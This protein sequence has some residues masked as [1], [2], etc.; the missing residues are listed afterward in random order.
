MKIWA[1]AAMLAFALPAGGAPAAE[2][3]VTY[4]D[5]MRWYERAAAEGSAE[6]QFLLGRLHEQGAAG[7]DRDPVRAAALYRAAAEQGYALA[8][9]SLG[10]LYQH[11]RGV[12]AD[13]A[14]AA[15]WFEAA[16]KQGMPAAQ[17]NLGYLMDRGI[18]VPQ[19]REAAA[20][21][22]R[23]AARQ[24]LARAMVNLGL[25]LAEEGIADRD[26]LVDA[27]VWLSLAAARGEPGAKRIADDIGAM[28]APAE[29]ARA[30]DALEAR[31]KSVPER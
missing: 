18:G 1:A 4:G 23:A 24:G 31:R 17:F 3:P 27:W 30:D 20:G 19:D 26:A 25:L 22:Y 16:A 6:A 13:A 15:R 14:E 2:P 12:V 29:R 21:W 11:G 28:L 10:L 9:F 7:R 8:Q 5:A